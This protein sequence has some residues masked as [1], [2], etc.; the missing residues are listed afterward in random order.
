MRYSRLVPLALATAFLATGCASAY[1]GVLTPLCAP[2]PRTGQECKVTS[3]GYYVSPSYYDTLQREEK[4]TGVPHAR[5]ETPANSAERQPATPVPPNV[6]A[7]AEGNPSE[8]P[9][10]P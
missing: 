10:A 2:N 3:D 5:G 1:H 8:T 6:H 9:E 4:T 7:D